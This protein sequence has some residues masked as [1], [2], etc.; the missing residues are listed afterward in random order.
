MMASSCDAVQ[1][2]L[3]PC[4][5]STYSTFSMLY[6]EHCVRAALRQRWQEHSAGPFVRSAGC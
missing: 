2:V 3:N 4:S 5:F 1:V 6:R